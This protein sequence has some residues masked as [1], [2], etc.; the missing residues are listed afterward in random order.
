MFVNSMAQMEEVTDES[1]RLCDIKPT[2][3]VL[4]IAECSEE[5]TDHPLNV[6]I[7][8]LIGKR[9]HFIFLK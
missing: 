2:G 8:H 4:K 6:Q 7:S 5:K 3:A 9:M 1:K